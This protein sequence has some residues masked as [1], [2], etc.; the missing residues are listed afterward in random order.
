MWRQRS[1]P[2]RAEPRPERQAK[3]PARLEVRPVV[4]ELGQPDWRA[5]RWLVRPE[6]QVRP[7][8]P[9]AEHQEVAADFVDFGQTQLMR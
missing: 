6:H 2:A 9:Q 4:A 5:L 3:L 8:L 7:R 1:I